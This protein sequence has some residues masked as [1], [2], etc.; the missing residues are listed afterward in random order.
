LSEAKSGIVSSRPHRR[1]PHFAALNA[2]Y[3][4]NLRHCEAAQRRKQSRLFLARL[5][6]EGLDCFVAFGSLYQRDLLDFDRSKRNGPD[7]AATRT[8]PPI[9]GSPA[10]KPQGLFASRITVGSSSD[11]DG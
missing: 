10:P 1:S 7:R 3:D 9:V 2:G 8:G 4:T 11:P 5:A 6:Q